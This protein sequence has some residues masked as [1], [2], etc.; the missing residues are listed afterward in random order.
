MHP[1]YEKAKIKI[2]GLLN[3]QLAARL[4]CHNP[5]CREVVWELIGGFK[6]VQ[7]AAR[8]SFSKN[9]ALKLMNRVVTSD[10]MCQKCGFK[11]IQLRGLNAGIHGKVTVNQA[12]IK[13]SVTNVKAEAS[14]G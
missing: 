11:V 7:A 14:H 6:F 12:P 1:L 10:V 2:D 9:G 3:V 4:I 5:A 8:R 13:E